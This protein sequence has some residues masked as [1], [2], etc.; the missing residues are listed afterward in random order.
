[1]HAHTHISQRRK[2]FL[3]GVKWELGRLTEVVIVELDLKESPRQRN[4]PGDGLLGGRTS[5]CKCPEAGK[6]MGSSAGSGFR[7]TEEELGMRLEG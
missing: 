6:I 3:S 2:L 7:V 1:M 5:M 4:G